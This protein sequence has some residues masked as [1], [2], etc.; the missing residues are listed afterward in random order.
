MLHNM[1]QRLDDPTKP[2]SAAVLDALH[3]SEALSHDSYCINVKYSF[4]TYAPIAFRCLRHMLNITDTAYQN[5][6]LKLKGGKLGAGKSGQLFYKSTDGR[7]VLKTLPRKEAEVLR[8]ILPTYYSH[9][10]A[11]RRDA[12]RIRSAASS[13]VNY[14]NIRLGDVGLRSFLARYFGLYSIEIS[15]DKRKIYLVC[16]ENA[17]SERQGM[18]PTRIFDLKGSTQ[19]RYVLEGKEKIDKNYSRQSDNGDNNPVLKD[20][21]WKKS[22][23]RIRLPMQMYSK[24]EVALKRDVDMLQKL[25]ICDYSLLVGVHSPEGLPHS[26]FWVSIIDTL[27][28]FNIQKRSERFMKKQVLGQKDVSCEDT[29]T[30]ARR[31]S[32]FATKYVFQGVDVSMPY[33]MGVQ[34]FEGFT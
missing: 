20:I 12:T 18:R 8:S 4:T 29:L 22:N 1:S 15:G 27:Q 3:F 25:N 33:D 7:F 6:L 26:Y 17:L 5:S 2:G 24:V 11:A 34:G 30:Y 32:E 9:L 14:P 23:L 10:F 19:G 28:L 21:N 31:F 16:M 13:A